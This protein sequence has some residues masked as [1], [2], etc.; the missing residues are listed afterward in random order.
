MLLRPLRAIFWVLLCFMTS[1]SWSQTGCTDP[2]ALNFDP[3]AL[4]DDGSCEVFITTYSENSSISIPIEVGTGISSDHAYIAYHGPLELAL[5]VNER[6][7]DDIVPEG[8]DYFALTGYSP[9]SFFD[10]TPDEGIA[11]WDYIFSIDMDNYVLEDFIIDFSIDFDP[12]EGPAEADA[13]V[14]PFSE[15]L[16]GIGQ[17]QSSIQQGAENLGFGYWQ[18][19]AGEDALLFDP[20]NPGVYDIGINL[21]NQGGTQLVELAIRV[22]VEDPI[23]GCSDPEACNYDDNVN[24]D[25]GSC[26]YGSDCTCPGDLNGDGIVGSSDLLVFLS[27]YAEPCECEVDYNEDQVVT[28]EDLLTFL[29][30]YGT[31]CID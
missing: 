20:L 10:S 14:L 9:T 24:L 22:I 7:V 21:Y 25:D 18:G 29:S 19:L 13:Y 6:F 11:K 2:F 26:L 16:T 27:F 30:Y 28:I 8:T 3:G 4:T 23:E 17:G 15:L 31:S 12:L 5:K 1:H